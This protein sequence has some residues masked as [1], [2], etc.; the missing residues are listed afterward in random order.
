M[1]GDEG[2]Y[3]HTLRRDGHFFVEIVYGRSSERRI[4][5]NG[6]GYRGTSGKA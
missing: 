2:T 3:R 6:R 4:L 5:H 1:H